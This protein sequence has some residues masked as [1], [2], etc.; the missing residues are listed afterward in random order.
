[1]SG[2]AEHVLRL[3]KYGYYFLTKYA[4]NSHIFLNLAKCSIM[5]TSKSV[6]HAPGWEV[7]NHKIFKECINNVYTKLSW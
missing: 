4:F 7:S 3:K 2:T 5:Y 6:P 1:M